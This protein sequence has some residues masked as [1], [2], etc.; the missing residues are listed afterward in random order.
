MGFESPRKTGVPGKDSV[1]G[2]G[3]E[4]VGTLIGEMGFRVSTNNC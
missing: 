3:G 4:K 2:G 1:G